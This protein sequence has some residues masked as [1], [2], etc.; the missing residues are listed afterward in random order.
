[1]TIDI[2][3]EDWI[4]AELMRHNCTYNR[5]TI[6]I[7]DINASFMLTWIIPFGASF[8]SDLSVVFQVLFS[9]RAFVLKVR[10]F[11]VKW[12][13]P[14]TKTVDTACEK[15][16]AKSPSAT[17]RQSSRL[18]GYR[19]KAY[20]SVHEIVINFRFHSHHSR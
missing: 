3:L 8:F 4:P 12:V 6:V 20:D 11:T 1:M 2:F 9:L 16:S 17:H 18:A 7:I 13:S 14:R 19:T 10:E 15:T 5:K